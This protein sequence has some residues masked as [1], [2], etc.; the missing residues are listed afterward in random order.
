MTNPSKLSK[1][2]ERK[3]QKNKTQIQ[4]LDGTVIQ[5]CCSF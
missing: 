1:Q 2:K 4:G 3:K 5:K